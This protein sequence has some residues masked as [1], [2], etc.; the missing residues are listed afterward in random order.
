MWVV[1]DN[2]N[3]VVEYTP[4]PLGANGSPTPAVTIHLPDSS[5]TDGLALDANGDLW[6]A[7]QDPS[8]VVEFTPDQL[9]TSGAPTPA[10]T[11]TVKAGPPG[12]AGT[13]GVSVGDHVRCAG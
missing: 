10:V 6:V 12:T 3:T 9:K 8:I 5:F 1:N 7:L 2:S 13:A 11:I 4:S